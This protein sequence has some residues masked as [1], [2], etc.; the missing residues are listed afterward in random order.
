MESPKNT[1]GRAFGY[2]NR[3]ILKKYWMLG[4]TDNSEKIVQDN[5]NRLYSNL[6][7]DLTKNLPGEQDGERFIFDAFGEKDWQPPSVRMNYCFNYLIR[8]GYPC[9]TFR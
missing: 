6:P 3:Y 8:Q 1:F 7:K 2:F 9:L 5:L 4:M